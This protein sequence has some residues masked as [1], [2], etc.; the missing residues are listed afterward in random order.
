MKKILLTL[1]L[2]LLGAGY[3]EAQGTLYQLSP[4]APNAQVLV[5]P[6]PDNGY[7]C[8]APAAIFSNAGLTTSVPQPV[9]LGSSGF[10]SFYIASGT[11]TIQ[12][13]GPGYNSGNR[14]VVTIG[15]SSGGGITPVT[16][17]PALP[18][19]AKT[20]FQLTTASNGFPA[21]FYICNSDG[22]GYSYAGAAN[23]VINAIDSANPP[24]GV[25]LKFLSTLAVAPALT[26]TSGSNIVSCTTCNFNT[27]AVV[28]YNIFATNHNPTGDGDALTA[29]VIIGSTAT[30]ISSIDSNTQIHISQNATGNSSSTT[31]WMLYG[32][33]EDA[34]ATNIETLMYAG[35][36]CVPVTFPGGYAWLNSAHWVSSVPASCATGQAAGHGA[37][38]NG[39]GKNSTHFVIPPTFNFA[40]AVNSNL[41]FSQA[42]LSV[43]GVYIDCGYQ[44]TMGNHAVNIV[45]VQQDA[46]LINFGILGCGG[47]DASMSGISTMPIQGPG[48]IDII[49]DSAGGV[50]FDF[51][52]GGYLDG[53]ASFGGNCSVAVFRNGASSASYINNTGFQMAPSAGAAGIVN[54]GN[55][56]VMHGGFIRNTGTAASTVCAT[57][58]TG[59]LQLDNV[60]M[61]SCNGS[62]SAAG[63]LANS[64]A[65]DVV[66][67]ATQIIAGSAANAVTLLGTA[68][69]L[70]KG[71]NKFSGNGANGPI[72]IGAVG[73]TPILA[74]TDRILTGG[75]NVYN[76]SAFGCAFTSGGGTSPSCVMQAGSTN[77]S[78]V[79][80]ASTGTGSPTS[81]GTIT[82]T[83]AGTYTLTGLTP[84]CSF[85]LDN[86]GT[87]WGAESVIFT[88]TQST[89]APTM[90][91]T[92][93]AA[94]TL[95]ALAVSSPYSIDYTCTP[96]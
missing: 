76:T 71:G 60:D 1:F 53:P 10:F 33:A 20:Q 31:G 84:R 58:N 5:C 68:K 92:N 36:N 44:R 61:T 9:Q 78:G 74:P 21:G 54:N 72:G 51:Q 41:F 39:K 95:T 15:S 8:P 85:Q 23:A 64:G 43:E 82:L 88:N 16:V 32:P 59:S 63:V 86:S 55:F 27:T 46:Q 48:L 22:L 34:G 42:G 81:T 37:Q 24:S 65:V 13:L 3:A 69:L 62:A 45:Q 89:T 19:T 93:I 14:Q 28:G 57:T 66:L 4:A 18:C 7:P 17:L 47:A 29:T 67:G 91:W 50:C 90:A 87:A 77:E 6:S 79:I 75:G 83:F 12:L 70:S 56:V 52:G 30:T 49:L 94:V 26:I 35:P 38:I 80:I 96:R 73:T 2:L 40:S 11:Y 25:P